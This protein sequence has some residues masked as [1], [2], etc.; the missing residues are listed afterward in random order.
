MSIGISS[1]DLNKWFDKLADWQTGVVSL[2]IHLVLI[3]L[4][5]GTV[6]YQVAKEPSDFTSE[7]GFVGDQS[8]EDAPAGPPELPPAPPAVPDVAV[9]TPAPTIS[10]ISTTSTAAPVFQVPVAT[11]AVSTF[12]TQMSADAAS[13]AQAAAKSLSAAGGGGGQGAWG[14]SSGKGKWGKGFGSM[15][16][17]DM[18]LTGVLY[19][20]KQ[21]P[22]GR[23]FPATEESKHDYGRV[24]SK[25][26]E[27]NYNPD[28]MKEFY[29]SEKPLYTSHI[30]IP[31]M[32]AEGGPK[33]FGLEKEVQ[34]KQWFVHYYGGISPPK[35]GRYRFWGEA[36]DVLV[37]SINS[38]TV[39]DNSLN[40]RHPSKWTASENFGPPGTERD[41]MFRPG[42]WIELSEQ[43]TY[44]LDVLIGEYP[45]GSFEAI[46]LVEQE[47][48]KYKKKSDGTPIVSVFSTLPL[49]IGQMPKME[50]AP[51]VDNEATVMTPKKNILVGG[52]SRDTL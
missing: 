25:F 24:L 48:K 8:E 32:K 37:V 27:S 7:S 12:S 49:S 50:N 5:G 17:D 26:I 41:R 51:P 18:M 20:L 1:K 34:P 40:G 45:G 9:L 6:L 13:A 4:L 33:A 29:R 43:E 16:K 42:D 19:D 3:L 31:L 28:S 35:S 22:D 52:T 23:P 38:K 30:F 2:I 10:A 44:R 36:D 14:K 15:E 46:L 21:T 11:T 47:G 39:L